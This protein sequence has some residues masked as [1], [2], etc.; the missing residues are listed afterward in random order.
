[1]RQSLEDLY[2]LL[3][4]QKGLL[5][6]LLDLSR[7]ERRIII[8]GE[9]DKLEDIVVKEM[10]E[11]RK[12][13]AIEKKRLELHP[14]IAADFGLTDNNL[15]V[16]DI[17]AHANPDERETL[18]TIQLEL[19]SLLKQHKDLNTENRELIE[20]HFEYTEAVLNLV[21]DYED[22]LN[23]FYGEDGKATADRKKSTGFFDS[24][25]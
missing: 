11:L 10:R 3:L 21:V 24:Q 17:V 20:A 7:E 9:A 19:T 12:L 15:T 2:G 25:A 18:R 23:N 14:A 5:E 1:M 13:N 16:T 8:A 4:E 22:P 6:K